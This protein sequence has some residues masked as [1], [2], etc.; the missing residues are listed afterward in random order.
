MLV[1]GTAKRSSDPRG[2]GKANRGLLAGEYMVQE[3][4][5]EEAPGGHVNHKSVKVEG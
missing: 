4:Y 3:F 1:S 5:G 2:G